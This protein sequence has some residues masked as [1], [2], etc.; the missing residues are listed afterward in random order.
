MEFQVVQVSSLEKVRAQDSLRRDEIHKKTV[1]AGERLSYQICMKA[2]SRMDV[3]VSVESGLKDAV[4]LYMVQDAYIDVPAREEDMEGEDYMTLEPGFMPDILVPLEEQGNRLA[5]TS[6]TATVWVKVDVPRDTPAGDYRIKVRLLPVDMQ[7]AKAP[8]GGR[9]LYGLPGDGCPRHPCLDAG[10][11]ADLH[12]V[13][14]CGLHR[15]A[16]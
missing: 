1:L 16:A 6:R 7:A 3:A 12:Q 14:L 4:R 11:E 13:V 2:D 8:G 9:G 10:A 5:V 15:G